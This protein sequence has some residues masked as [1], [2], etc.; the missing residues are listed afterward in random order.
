MLL[1][2]GPNV[3]FTWAHDRVRDAL[4]KV[5]G[6]AGHD[7]ALEFGSLTEARDIANRSLLALRTVGAARVRQRR[8]HRRHSTARRGGAPVSAVR[9]RRAVGGRRPGRWWD[10]RPAAARREARGG[11]QQRRQ[12][13][14]GRRRK[15][16]DTGAAAAAA[17]GVGNSCTRDLQMRAEWAWRGVQMTSLTSINSFRQLLA[18]LEPVRGDKT[19]ILISGGWPLDD[20]EQHTLMATVASEAAAARATLYT[21][22]VPGTIG[23]A[24]RRMMTS[25]PA[26]D[27]YLH[28]GPLDTLASMTGGA[29]LSRRG[30]RRRRSSSGSAA[31]CPASTASAWRRTRP[32]P[33]AR[34]GA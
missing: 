4:G 33:T 8:R 23:S 16:N 25:T 32:T 15:W 1:P 24:S 6:Q 19:V 13:V 11:R 2:A 14:G 3:N 5:I 20:R 10:G 30:R 17:A 21:L 29:S 18:A 31:S 7:T 12:A 28:S 27:S 26:N 22:F 34:G 9:R